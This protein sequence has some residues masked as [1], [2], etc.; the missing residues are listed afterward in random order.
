LPFGA[1]VNLVD[2]QLSLMLMHLGTSTD[3][4][5][6]KGVARFF[7]VARLFFE[8]MAL[9][10]KSAKPKDQKQRDD[11]LGFHGNLPAEVDTLA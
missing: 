7:F 8:H 9:D 10:R 4:V 5:L 3:F 2:H 6:S 1:L 11:T